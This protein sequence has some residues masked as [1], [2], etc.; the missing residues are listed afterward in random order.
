MQ[1]EPI[2]PGPVRGHLLFREGDDPCSLIG[3]Q[4]SLKEQDIICISSPVS[5][6]PRGYTKVAL[7][8]RARGSGKPDSRETR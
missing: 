6:E 8:D 3:E 1:D 2:Q 7:C 5:S 4:V